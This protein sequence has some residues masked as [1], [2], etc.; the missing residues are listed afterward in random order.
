MRYVEAEFAIRIAVPLH[1]FREP[2]TRWKLRDLID[3]IATD[4][5][6]PDGSRYAQSRPDR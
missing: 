4:A 2:L 3:L 5:D 6:V 1:L